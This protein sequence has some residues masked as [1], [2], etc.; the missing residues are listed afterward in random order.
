[1]N[2]KLNSILKEAA[3]LTVMEQQEL[4]ENIIHLMKQ[5][6][7]E[8]NKWEDIYGIG[9]GIWKGIDAQDYVNQMRED[10]V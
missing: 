2:N 10:R 5:T 1:M 4:I 7:K 6:G 3:T 9:R 8:N